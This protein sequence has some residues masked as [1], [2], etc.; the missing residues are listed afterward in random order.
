MKNT[1]EK[2]LYI[3][4]G[5]MIAALYI[6]FTWV[7]EIFGLAYLTPQ[8]RLGEA[9]CVLVWFTPAAVPGLFAGCFLA[10]LTMGCVIWD[11]VL[12]SLTTLFAAVIAR[13]IKCR[14]L[15]PLPNV[16]LN[17][18]VIPFV[19]LYF[20]MDGI[21]LPL[22]GATAISVLFGEVASA[23]VIGLLLLF[24]VDRKGIFKRK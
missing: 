2:I 19:I 16:I 15:V 3:T 21:S 20:Y 22:Y 12:G 24:S 18:A 13:K 4:Y 8:I 7:S 11:V 1:R 5:A 10:N 6:L 14:W 23:Y 9:L 17:T